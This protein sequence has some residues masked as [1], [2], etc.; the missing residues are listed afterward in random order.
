MLNAILYQARTGCPWRYLPAE[1]GRWTTIGKTFCR[2]RDRGVWQQAMDVLRRMLRVRE[3]R[4]PSAVEAQ[5]GLPGHQRR[6]GR[7]VVP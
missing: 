3:G 4:E 7:P 1:F 2:W 6:P 5:G